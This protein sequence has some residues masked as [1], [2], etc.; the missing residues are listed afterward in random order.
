MRSAFCAF[1]LIVASTSA[2]FAT[3]EVTIIMRFDHRHSEPA[4]E[5]MKRELQN[6]MLDSSVALSWRNADEL[7]PTESFSRLVVVTF[8]GSCESRSSAPHLPDEPV[9]L[10]YSHVSD[11]QVIPF[12]EVECDR[13]RGELGTAAASH[14]PV[15]DRLLGRAMGR[16]LAH[17]LHHIIYHT[18][19]HSDT[20][21]FRKSLS[22]QD[23]I[24]DRTWS[25]SFTN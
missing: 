10:G 23:L 15:A 16:V 24:I 4:V 21:L 1:L 14:G 11:G 18:R 8:H 17:E 25:S 9:I 20:G 5:E 13:I 7:S 3:A 12:A 19:T 6:V 22:P 2:A